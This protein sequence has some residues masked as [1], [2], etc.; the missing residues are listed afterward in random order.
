[1]LGLKPFKP[2]KI[3]EYLVMKVKQLIEVLGIK[4]DFSGRFLS[5][6]I[7][8]FQIDSRLIRKGDFFVPLKGT[9]HDGHRFIPDALEKG[10]SGFFSQNPTGL[11]G[12]VPV[13]D[14]LK[15]L[16]EVGKFKRK[17]LS[18]AIGIT[19]TSGKTTTKELISAGLEGFYRT[20]QTP[21]NYNN[22]IGVPLTLANIPEDAQLGVFEFG[23]G[24]VGDIRHLVNIATPEIR[25]LTSVGHGHT[26]KFGSF[27]NVIKGKGEIFEG[28]ELAIL[29][30]SLQRY[31]DLSRKITFGPE[32]DADIRIVSAMVEHSGTA[33]VFEVNGRRYHVK[34]PVYNLSTI[35]N[36]GILL[37]VAVYLGISPEKVL[38]NIS[39]FQLPEG[40]GKVL[41][42]GGITVI[43][44]T[45]N[46]NPLSVKNAIKTLSAI[47]GFR[48]IVLG[49]MLELGEYSD[50]LHR[51]IG[52]LVASS[53]IDLAVFYGKK[54]KLAYNEA[55]RS[56]KSFYSSDKGEIARIIKSLSDNNPIVLIKGS[57]GMKM[58][59]VIQKIP[60]F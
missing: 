31:Y 43:D 52:R 26:E 32:E 22:E 35:Y 2:R 11:E 6:D 24:K 59:E 28:G 16:T 39:E 30:Y 3:I 58:E 1:M 44:D 34:L 41:K 51:E 21:G 36:I 8:D 18:I 38:G 17:R 15:A 9:R 57:R 19:G 40:R 23:A 10:A 20:Y 33:G 25:I 54:M 45:Y 29:P 12:E 4:G 5:R 55:V 49:D 7:K 46:A 56:V 42:F 27:E 48:V 14:T 47:P 37:A 13:D 50:K 53:D 60:E